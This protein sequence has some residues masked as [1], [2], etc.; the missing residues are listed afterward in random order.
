MSAVDFAPG[1]GNISRPLDAARQTVGGPVVTHLIAT[2]G[3]TPVLRLAR[4]GRD[5]PVP[6][7]AKL[8]LRSPTGSGK[9][10]L[11]R[12]ALDAL[13]ASDR[14]APGQALVVPST[15]NAAVSM[16]WACA[17]R[18][19]AVHAVIPRASSLEFRQLLQLYRAKVELSPSEL[20]VAGARERAA[21]LSRELGACLWDPFADD[22]GLDGLASLGAEL[23]AIDSLSGIVCGLGSG[24]TARALRRALPGVTLFAVEPS[25]SAVNGGG[26]R[27]PHKVHGIGVGFPSAHLSG[28]DGVRH[29]Q[30]SMAEAW[31]AK[32]RVAAEEGLFVGPTTGAVLAAAARL[33]AEVRGPLVGIAMDTGER[34]FSQE[35][36]VP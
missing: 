21:A 28:V 17:T 26:A 35:A 12:A 19:H 32:R 5:L 31:A 2:I 15:G 36:L 18:G 34:Y 3:E 24:A 16:A 1:P 4:F 23:G 29:V 25:E 20:G 6:L 7:F 9:D 33:A 22:A 30:V 13:A 14:L 10:R 27:G 8:E 11:A